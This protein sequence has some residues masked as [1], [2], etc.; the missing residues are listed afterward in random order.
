MSEHEAETPQVVEVDEQ[1]TA[2]VRGSDV[3]MTELTDFFDRAFGALGGTV[4]VR[5]GAVVGPAF[6]RYARPPSDTA[7]LEA[8]FPVS[9]PVE[10]D[11]DVLPSALPGGR[12]ARLVHHGSYDELGSSW[13]RLMTWA[14]EQGLTHTGVFWEV[15]L[16]EPTPDGDPDAM[17]TELNLLLG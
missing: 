11:G 17:R 13:A 3:P 9:A 5:P 6:A 8:G 12:V 15:Y 1:P 4:A 16:T 2:V 7:D 10:P 14:E